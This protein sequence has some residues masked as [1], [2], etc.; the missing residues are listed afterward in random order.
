MSVRWLIIGLLAL[1]AGLLPGCQAVDAAP[2]PTQAA[3]A[4][5]PSPTSGVPATFTAGAATA[6]ATPILFAPLQD[7]PTPTNTPFIP[8]LT[9]FTPRPSETPTPTASPLIT[10]TLTPVIKPIDQYSYQEVIPYQ[11]FPTPPGDN[12]WGMH[13]IP[14]VSQD[15][16]VVDRFV[17]E[18]VNMHIKWWY[19]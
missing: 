3:A 14:T 1:A 18:M 10:P 2:L 6:V 5:L 7:T 4:M 16:G 8:T 13:W 11:A 12:G 15:Q 19:F 9:P 17:A